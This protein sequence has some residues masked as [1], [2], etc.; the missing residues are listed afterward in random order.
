MTN[1]QSDRFLGK[2]HDCYF[3]TDPRINQNLAKQLNG[4]NVVI[5]G[6]GRGI[7]R[8]CAELL[9]YGEVKSLSLVALEQDEL[10]ETLKICKAIHQS[11]L[12]KTK[13]FDVQDPNAV[14]KFLAEV[15]QEFGG[16]DVVVMNAGR[17]PQ[18]LP[19]AEGDPNIWW[20]TVGVSLRGAYNFSRYALPVM[21]KNGGG[22][23]IFT[24]SAGA[25]ANRGMS[26]YI[27]AKLAMVR[28]AEII[29]VENFSEH[30]IKVFAIHPGSIPTR[31]YHDFK[32]K[33]EGRPKDRSYIIENAEGEEKSAQTAVKFLEKGI[34]DTPYMAA[35]MVSVLASGQLDFM[36][37]RYVDCSI[38]VEEYV[39]KR[40]FITQ[41][42]LY[43]VRL[44][45]GD[46]KLVPVLDF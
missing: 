9:S 31:F 11:L 17:P 34:F 28:L 30:N 42:D 1:N 44:N 24:A 20:D 39:E 2:L 14:K 13:A 8:A 40:A 19:T 27:T 29:H 45:A 36:S 33:V 6:A 10:D 26:S 43:R 32:D 16:I 5:A 3:A 4:K 21:Q 23:M 18:W 7:G 38:K 15:D 22:R 37:G 35:G 46:G 41:N 12:T 25:H